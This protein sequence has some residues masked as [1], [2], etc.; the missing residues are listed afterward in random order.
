MGSIPVAHPTPPRKL[1]SSRRFL[2]AS[3]ILVCGAIAVTVAVA[4][5][6]SNSSTPSLVRAGETD[7][8]VIGQPVHFEDSHFWLVRLS[9]SEFVALVDRDTHEVF[10]TDDCLIQWREDI[11]FGG[12]Q[13]VFRGKCSGSNFDLVG[14]VLSGPSP[15]GMDRHF[16]S[17]ED[18]MVLVDTNHDWCPDD[19]AR[20]APSCVVM[21]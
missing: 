9:A 14:N 21:Y 10:S 3:L 18:G 7:D 5:A 17:V 8:Y 20:G 15:R 2:A 12:L 19:P 6:L 1:R 11:A 13:G 16:V 4:F